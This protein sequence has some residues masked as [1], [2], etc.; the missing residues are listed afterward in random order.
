MGRVATFESSRVRWPSQPASTK[1]AVA[2][3][4]SP[5]RPS[6]LFPSR[7]AA[8]SSGSRTRS[9]VEASANS[10]GW[11]MNERPSA[12]STSSVRSS[13]GSLGS[14]KGVVSFRNTRKYRSTCM[15]TDDGCTLASSNGSMT[16]RPAFSC[17]RIDLSDRI[18]QYPWSPSQA[19]ALRRRSAKPPSPRSLPAAL[20]IFV[21]PRGCSSEAEHQLPKLRTRVR[22]PSPALRLTAGDRARRAAR[23]DAAAEEHLRLP[24]SAVT[25]REQLDVAVALAAL[26]LVLVHGEDVVVTRRL[27]VEHLL[28]REPLSGRE[29]PLEERVLVDVVVLRARED[30]LIGEQSIHRVPILCQIRVEHCPDSVSVGHEHLP[31]S[32]ST[33]TTILMWRNHRVTVSPSAP[34]SGSTWWCGR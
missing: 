2:C 31:R 32:Y 30:E 21:A 28:G 25:H 19:P 1:P 9:S 7:R 14:M 27:H 26:Q 18:T 11:R 29:A 13:C 5:R 20:G 24:D 6:E 34:C 12:T 15:S 3:V 17:S 16:M 8:R 22:F 10:A 4:S 23:S 33:R